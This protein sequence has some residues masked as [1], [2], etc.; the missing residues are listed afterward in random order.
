M[1]LDADR[2]VLV[3]PGV[4]VRA[5]S[6]IQILATGLG[7]VTPEWPSGVAAPMDNPPRVIA[8][9]RVLVDRVPVNVTRATLAPGY[10][11]LYLVEVEL[12]DVVNVGPTEV[13]IEAG[14]QASGRVT[15]QL[16]QQ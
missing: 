6:R 9:V 1:I 10:V 15:L 2:G 16:T 7:R 5:G 4:A 8:P 14:G 12:P 13:Y 3:E 11:G